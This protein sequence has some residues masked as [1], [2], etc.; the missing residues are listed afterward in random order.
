MANEKT[1]YCKEAFEKLPA[2]KRER[3]LR[4]ACEEF[5]DHGFENTSIQQIA[6][7][8]EISVGAVYKYFD[9]KEALFI[10]VVQ[11]GLSTLEKML[12]TLSESKEDIAVKAEKIIRT[13]LAFS[14]EKPELIKIYHSLTVSGSKET[15]IGLS[16]RIEAI[17]AS[18]Y[19]VAISEAQRT[20]DVR[21]DVDP[22]FFAFLLDNIFMM[23]QF[24]TAC[25]YFKERFFI[26][27]G[28]QAEECDD[29]IV[30]QTLLFIKAAFNFK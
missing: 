20:G 7:K 12:M 9:D 19:T 25:D 14:R 3:V 15:L 29:L 8:A 21:S 18:I 10:T 16:Q 22:A 24:S 11:E 30:Q 4:A 5:A 28:R 6:R 13:L 23:L 27:T 1:K 17:S 2:E 26:Y